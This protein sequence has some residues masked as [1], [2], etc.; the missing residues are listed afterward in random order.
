M[1]DGDDDDDDDDGDGDGDDDDDD[2]D[3]V[4]GE[5]GDGDDD[6]DDDDDEEEDDN[7]KEEVYRDDGDDGEGDYDDGIAE[8]KGNE[9]REGSFTEMRNFGFLPRAIALHM[10]MPSAAAVDS[11]RREELDMGIA[12]RSV[13]MVWK[14]RR[15][16]RRPWEI[17]AW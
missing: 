6:D 7:S 13:T 12:V 2:D 9:G 3:D 10:V 8:G 14:L 17:S 1:E 11:S 4:D 5:D 15:D 16:S